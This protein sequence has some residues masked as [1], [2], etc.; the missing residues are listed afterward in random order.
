MVPGEAVE[1][2]GVA[3]VKVADDLPGVGEVGAPELVAGELR[4]K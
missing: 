3:G 2:D 1:V 4:W